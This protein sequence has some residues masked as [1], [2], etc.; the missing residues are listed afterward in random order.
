MSVADPSGPVP[1]AGQFY[2]LAGAQD[3]GGGE[4]DRPFLPRPL[5]VMRRLE[6]GVLEFLLADVG[7]GTHRLC[8]LRGGDP[9]WLLGPLGHG[10]APP[11]PGRRPVLVG[12]GVGIAPLVILQEALGPGAVVLAGFRD[13]AHALAAP[14]L[15]RARLATNDGSVGHQGSVMD[16]LQV[17]LG[18]QWA[19]EIY[20]CGPP[21]MLEAVRELCA[22]SD[23]P[24]QLALETE[25]AC[26][27][28]A[29][30]GCVVPTRHGYVRLCVDG[31]VLDACDLE[32]SS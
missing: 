31:P 10:F 30:F 20:A 1:D 11:R 32:V 29:C 17:E 28:G 12:G 13:A 9:V 15:P 5:S 26:G 18:R 8:G 19:A 7:P 6:D 23:V 27:F 22:A 14:L 16:L 25:M 24:A 3:W 2:M 21:R 4:D